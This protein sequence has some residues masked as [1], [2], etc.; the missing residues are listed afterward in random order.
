[1]NAI[2]NATSVA[3]FSGAKI[4]LIER[5]LPPYA[6]YWTLPGGRLEP[7]ESI[8]S[9]A[10]REILE[11]LGL[12]IDALIPI[13][14]SLGGEAYILQI[15]ATEWQGETP[16]PNDEIAD[17]CWANLADVAKLRTTPGLMDILVMAGERL[18][19]S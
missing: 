13:T 14:Q 3:L 6:N 11:E 10:R 4:L 1:M 15:Y 17:W 8:E 9:C 16:A 18:N 5:A 19:K 7:F 12:Q 2:P